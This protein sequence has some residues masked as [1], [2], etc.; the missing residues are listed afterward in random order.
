MGETQQADPPLTDSALTEPELR[1][2][3][4]RS[5]LSMLSPRP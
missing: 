4:R 2:T 1:A 5:L 3:R